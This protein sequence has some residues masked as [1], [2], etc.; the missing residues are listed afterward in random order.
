MFDALSFS[1]P[2]KT[3]SHRLN[4]NYRRSAF[5]ERKKARE[6]GHLDFPSAPPSLSPP[7]FNSMA[8]PPHKLTK[9]HHAPPLHAPSS[10][11]SSSLS[12]HASKL[13]LDSKPPLVATSSSRRLGLVQGGEKGKGKKLVL[14]P[15]SASYSLLTSLWRRLHGRNRFPHLF[16]LLDFLSATATKTPIRTPHP[17]S[18]N[19]RHRLPSSLPHPRV[20]TSSLH[21]LRIGRRFPLD[22]LSESVR[23]PI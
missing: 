3:G 23:G 19:P 20:A 21:P 7:H 8:S 13:A 9:L 5:N 17:H 11:S 16:L 15:K 2:R 10:S 12:A 18:R 22:F 4:T 6:E 1:P 14:K